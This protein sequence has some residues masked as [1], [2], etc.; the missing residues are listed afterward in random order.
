M[1][2]RPQPSLSLMSLSRRF[3]IAIACV[4][5][6]APAA[7]SRP[8]STP[9]AEFACLSPYCEALL[10]VG[11][12][13]GWGDLRSTPVPHEEIRFTTVDGSINAP[14][15]VLRVYRK[16]TSAT[17]HTV[18]GELGFW[19]ITP[20]EPDGRPVVQYADTAALIQRGC[21]IPQRRGRFT[22]CHVA[23]PD[24]AGIDWAT[25]FEEIRTRGAWS[26]TASSAPEAWTTSPVLVLERLSRSEYSVV[27][28]NGVRRSG[29]PQIA[30]HALLARFLD[31]LALRAAQ[32]HAR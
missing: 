3:A 24:E 20:I 30:H 6:L 25:A 5:I 14:R 16:R 1:G 13:L 21:S 8:Q 27:I 32:A 22:V 28:D 9:V 12:L 31:S 15:P 26:L 7:C 18:R 10:P 17:A 29:V 2:V 11:L 4:G 19:W 23:I